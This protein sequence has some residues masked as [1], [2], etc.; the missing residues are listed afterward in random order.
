M[1]DHKLKALCARDRDTVFAFLRG[2]KII[3][4]AA[5]LYLNYRGHDALVLDEIDL[6]DPDPAFLAA[7]GEKPDAIYLWVIA[8]A[9][10]SA[11]GHVAKIFAARR[12][13]S[14]DL[15]TRPVTD[16]GIRLMTGLGF[17]PSLSWSPD[18]WVYHRLE[19]EF[20]VSASL[21]HA[22]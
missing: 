6:H 5:F 9:G 3:G 7:P 14:A 11:L 18:L 17:Q 16:A 4:G 22:A 19:R 20:S 8:G 1:S 12:Y 13:R 15:Y 10:R 21:Q 2:R